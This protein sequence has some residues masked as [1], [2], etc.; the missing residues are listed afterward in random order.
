MYMFSPFRHLCVP[1]Y[2]YIQSYHKR[3][4]FSFPHRVLR[5]S[6][7]FPDKMKGSALVGH[8][9]NNQDDYWIIKGFLRQAGLPDETIHPDKGLP[10]HKP[11]H[12]SN[13][14]RGTGLLT[15]MCVVIVLVFLI[16]ATRL[17]LRYFR[18]DLKWGWD[19]WVI[20]P[21]AV[22]IRL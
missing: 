19:D 13:D 10:I 5:V 7:S 11:P 3:P 9:P 21:A 16:T 17:S 4:S 15:A 22:C 6:I 2:S 1:E 18:N 20:I 12:T 14:D 8:P